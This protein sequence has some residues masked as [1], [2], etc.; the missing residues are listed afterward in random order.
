MNNRSCEHAIAQVYFYLDGEITWIRR[1]RVSRHLRRCRDCSGAYDFESRLKVIVRDRL[2][3]E[4]PPEAIG[5]LAAFLR[6]NESG[7]GR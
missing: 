7:F 5:R 4:P 1:L 6:E 3:V 2:F